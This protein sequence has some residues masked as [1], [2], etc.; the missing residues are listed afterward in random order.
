MYETA[1]E[2]FN[3]ES[4]R[5]DVQFRDDDDEDIRRE[6]SIVRTINSEE[7]DKENVVD[8]EEEKDENLNDKITIEN[9]HKTEEKL[10]SNEETVIYD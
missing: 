2:D 8:I 3:G 1:D 6:S 10:P 5:K 9:G 7:F 4:V